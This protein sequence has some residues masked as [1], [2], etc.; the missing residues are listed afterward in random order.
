MKDL[1]KS[2]FKDIYTIF[3]NIFKIIGNTILII[4]ILLLSPFTF[5]I[6]KIF[7]KKINDYFEKKRK[8]ER[9]KYIDE[10][11]KKL[12]RNNQKV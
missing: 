6:K 4:L 10:L 11:H 1:L 9:E 7:G 5:I 2:I 8:K 12:H 3:K